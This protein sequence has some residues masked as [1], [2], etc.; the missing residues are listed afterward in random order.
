MPTLQQVLLAPGTIPHGV[1]DVQ[2][3]IDGEV[4]AKSGLSGA[5]LV[6]KYVG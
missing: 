1:P 3:M 6:Q 4:S 2:A 5:G